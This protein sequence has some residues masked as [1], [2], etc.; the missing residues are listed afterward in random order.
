MT[1]T[2]LN[3]VPG[4]GGVRLKSGVKGCRIDPGTRRETLGCEPE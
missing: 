2:E 1:L 3:R 4:R